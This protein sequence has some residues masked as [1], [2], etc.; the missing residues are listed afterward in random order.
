MGMPSID[1]TI[2]MAIVLCSSLRT[3]EAGRAYTSGTLGLQIDAG[4][5]SYIELSKIA[6]RL[7]VVR[8]GRLL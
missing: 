2:V 1:E 5:P 4:F 7:K 8:G 3:Y 6:F